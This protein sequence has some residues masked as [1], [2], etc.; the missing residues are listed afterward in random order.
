MSIY[1]V[2]SKILLMEKNSILW[3]IVK[4]TWNSSLLKKLKKKK[5]KEEVGIMKSPEKMAG[6]SGTNGEENGNP[7]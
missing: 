2:F 1:L 7:L 4:G 5:K 6:G 3:K